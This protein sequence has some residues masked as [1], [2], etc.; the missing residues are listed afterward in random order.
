MKK[1]SLTDL[2]V[3]SFVTG[4]DEKKSETAKGGTSFNISLIWCATAQACIPY[5]MNS[6]PHCQVD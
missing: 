6:N 3:K 5:T 1:V 4:L 2:K